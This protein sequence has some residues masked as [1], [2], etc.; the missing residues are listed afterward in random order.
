MKAN[1]SPHS[2]RVDFMKKGDDG[3]Q[4]VFYEKLTYINIVADS[5]SQLHNEEE[6][7]TITHNAIN[8][9]DRPNTIL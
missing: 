1:Y 2:R 5:V 3:E 9:T 4:H 7:K 6:R 8:F